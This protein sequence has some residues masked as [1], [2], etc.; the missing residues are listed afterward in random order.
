MQPDGLF[1]I[2]VCNTDFYL[3][4]GLG[5][6]AEDEQISVPT[7]PPHLSEWNRRASKV[8]IEVGISF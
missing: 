8:D 4:L 1:I 6:D 5:D 7:L 2:S 3:N